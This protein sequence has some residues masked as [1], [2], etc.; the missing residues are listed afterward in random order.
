MLGHSKLK[1]LNANYCARNSF[2]GSS[3][4]EIGHVPNLLLRPF[5]MAEEVPPHRALHNWAQAHKCDPPVYT[6]GRTEQGARGLH[7]IT[8]MMAGHKIRAQHCS[9]RKARDIAQTM[10]M[11]IIEA[12]C[13]ST[14]HF[15]LI[16]QSAVTPP[17]F[18]QQ[19]PA[20]PAPPLPPPIVVNPNRPVVAAWRIASYSYQ[21]IVVYQDGSVEAT[22]TESKSRH[23]QNTPMEQ[24]A[25]IISQT[26]LNWG[27][28]KQ[29][30][31]AHV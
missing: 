10:L 2:T 9:K 19:I 12:G 13:G 3:S 21:Y 5:S 29:I 27:H 4:L 17:G 6:E 25:P 1:T 31:R 11:T 7:V 28:W 23:A 8:I 24:R 16:H 14:G 15:C 20:A 18:V 30:G 26:F 22:M